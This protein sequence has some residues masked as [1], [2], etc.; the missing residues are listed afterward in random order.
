VPSE[1]LVAR[2]LGSLHG[3]TIEAIW[4]SGPSDVYLVGQDGLVIH[5]DGQKWARI[6]VDVLKNG[7]VYDVT[8]TSSK[9]VWFATS[10]VGAV[11]FDGAHWV[12]MK[13]GTSCCGLHAISP[14]NVWGASAA[15]VDHYDGKTWSITGGTATKGVGDVWASSATDVYV[16]DDNATLHHY[17]GKV[18]SKVQWSLKPRVENGK[19]LM[20]TV[21]GTGPNDVFVGG[22]ESIVMHFDGKGWTQHDV[23]SDTRDSV[24]SLMGSASDDVY[25]ISMFRRV[26]RYDG[27]AWS[28]LSELAS[29]KHRGQA[30]WLSGPED[31]WFGLDRGTVVRFQRSWTVETSGTMADLEA[32]TGTGGELWAVGDRGTVVHHQAGAWKSEVSGV[33]HRLRA[34]TA[35]SPS[36]VWAVGDKGTIVHWDGKTW[37]SHKSASPQDLYAVWSPSADRAVAVGASGTIVEYRDKTWTV[38]TAPVRKDLYALSPRSDKELMAVGSGGA[39][40]RYDGAAWTAETVDATATLRSVW[41]T[42]AKNEVWVASD[43]GTVYQQKNGRWEKQ[44]GAHIADLRGFTAIDNDAIWAVRGGELAVRSGGGWLF[45]RPPKAAGRASSFLD[46][47]G[48]SNDQ[49]VLVGKSGAILRRQVRR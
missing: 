34:V 16:S 36:N 20:H 29:H 19:P 7:T 39:L 1:I 32:V 10:G 37:T 30:M 17:D 13:G 27:T 45:D 24:M 23:G 42:A 47:W 9:D 22:G 35:S 43:D 44:Q 33:K 14:S 5:Y 18:W 21:W 46:V 31:L 25:A 48:A 40:L 3:E 12:P 8:G 26:Y 6:G 38:A 41:G 11:H 28:W 2:V 15:S 4:G 49:L